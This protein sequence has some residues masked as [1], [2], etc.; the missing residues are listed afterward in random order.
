MLSLCFFLIQNSECKEDSR[1][2]Y[3]T[4]I[5]V[6]LQP[7]DLV[8]ATRLLHTLVHTFN[9]DTSTYSLLSIGEYFKEERMDKEQPEALI[10]MINSSNLPLVYIDTSNTRIFLLPS[11]KTTGDVESDSGFCEASTP[12]ELDAAVIEISSIKVTPRATNPLSRIVVD[13]ELYKRAVRASITL[14]PGSDIEDRQYQLDFCGVSLICG[15]WEDLMKSEKIEDDST[16]QN[17]ALEWN[18]M[19]SQNW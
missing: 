3:I 9:V 19:L 13:E 10:P 12:F 11:D 16:V 14:Y 17:P 18:T 4:E 7:C 6:T 2:I 8:L 5:C 15:R 1:R